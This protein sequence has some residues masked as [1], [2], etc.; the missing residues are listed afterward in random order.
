MIVAGISDVLDG[1]IARR[2]E[3]YHPA[4]VWLD[5]LC[6][7]IFIL[8]ALG[9]VSSIRKPPREIPFSI[10]S[11]E[12]VQLPFVV[13]YW[14]SRMA[15]KTPLPRVN[16]QS[17]VI[18]K[19]TTLSQFLAIGALLMRNQRTRPLSTVTGILGLAASVFYIQRT[20]SSLKVTI[21]LSRIY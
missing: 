16:F 14:V 2:M 5:P 10:A 11:R 6:D 18:G 12:I 4:G 9:A 15:G 3:I 7:K 8:A 20:F 17:S 21:P 13:L 19:M 1:W